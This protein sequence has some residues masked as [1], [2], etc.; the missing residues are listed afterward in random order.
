[1][2]TKFILAHDIGT[3]GD[4]ATLFDEAGNLA[5]SAYE[6][7]RTYL[8]KVNQAEQDANDWWNAVVASTRRLI[9]QACVNPKD[10]VAVGFSGQMMALL[11]VDCDGIPLIPALIHM[12]GRSAPQSERFMESVGKEAIYQIT[13]NIMDPHYTIAKIMWL[14]EN[15]PEVYSRTH[16]ILQSKDY[17]AYKFTGRLGTTDPSDASLTLM[18]DIVQHKWSEEIVQ[19]LGIPMSILP[20][21]LKSTDI[22]GFVTKEAAEATGLLEGTP[23]VVG[24]G[25]GV[26]AT[27]GSGAL[28]KG[29]AYNYIG[30]SSW[31]SIHDDKPMFDRK[32]RFFSCCSMKDGAYDMFGTMLCG[33]SSFEWARREL[34]AVEEFASH[35][36]GENVYDMLGKTVSKAEPGAGGVVFL[37]HLMGERAPLWDPAAKGVFYG[38]SLVTSRNDLIRAVLEGVAFNL[39][40]IERVFEELGARI[41]EI[42]LIGGGAKSRVWREILTNVYGRTTVVPQYVSE[43][44]SFGAAI[45]AGVGVGLYND[46]DESVRLVKE[47]YREQPEPELVRL[48]DKRA[49]VFQRLYP[50]LRDVFSQTAD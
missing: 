24:G 44:T 29:K 18:Y 34:G 40:T 19:E 26:C 13:G 28:V 11:P 32:M 4:K 46:L 16:K 14:K 7:Y 8:P 47:V 31:V 42:S 6:E 22:Q 23:V 20:D 2:A 38:L 12:D 17:V 39:R 1:M 33:G 48:Y 43:A 49:R 3:T 15:M 10:I 36:L 5:G 9:Q 21:V 50:A 35:H 25:D 45:A 30:G 27:V 41:S 37:P